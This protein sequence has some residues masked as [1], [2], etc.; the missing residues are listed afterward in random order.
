MKEYSPFLKIKQGEISALINLSPHDRK[1]IIP[2]LEPPRDDTYTE[3][4]LIRKIDRNAK[5]II[6][7]ILPPFLFYLD[8]YEIPDELQIHG[9]DTY[10]YLID[11]FKEFEII[12]VI[13]FDRSKS[14]NQIGINYANKKSK[15]IAFRITSDYFDSFLAYEK[16][17][18]RIISALNPDVLCTVLLDCNYIDDHN[19]ANIEKNTI[20]ILKNI[21]ELKLFTKIVISGSSIPASIGDKV[22]T[23]T[24]KLIPRNEV[25]LFRK[26][27]IK[28]P[29]VL[30][31]FGD[32]TVISP[33][34]SE[35]NVEPELIQNVMTSKIIYSLLDSHFIC[36][37]G[38][39]KAYGFEQYFSHAERII[40]ESFFRGSGFSWGDN[41]LYEKAIHGGKNITPST[42]IGPEVNAHI[43]LMINETL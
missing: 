8:N 6:K 33:G 5:R 22:K 29:D 26:T 19:A 3:E 31:I 24:E 7:K 10:L 41:Y 39:I 34:Y 12:P 27:I 38:T 30:L 11:A 28:Y 32:Y 43:K 37:G 20:K 23:N 21:I 9:E 13:G 16:D 36:R 4:D 42:I 25:N 14:H 35:I 15:K 17:L 18:E 2:L 1:S 40:G